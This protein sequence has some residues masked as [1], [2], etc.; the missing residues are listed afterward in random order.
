M[1]LRP[2]AR[3]WEAQSP[4]MGGQSGWLSRAGYDEKWPYS[5][6]WHLYLQGR[7]GWFHDQ[8]LWRMAKKQ[9]QAQPLL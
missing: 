1:P 2:L 8:D 3:V 6:V 7:A 9:H 5:A 4:Q